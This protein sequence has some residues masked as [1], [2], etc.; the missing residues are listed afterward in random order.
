[1]FRKVLFWVLLS[2]IIICLILVATIGPVDPVTI[3]YLVA[4]I[5]FSILFCFGFFNKYLKRKE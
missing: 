1:M 2:T 5:M 4:A 3:I